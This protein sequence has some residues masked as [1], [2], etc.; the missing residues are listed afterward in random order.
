MKH[1]HSLLILFTL[2]AL[3][4]NA[5]TV[6]GINYEATGA[7]TA[8]VVAKWP[9]Y[10]GTVT[11]PRTVTYS[12]VSYTVNEIDNQCFLN[13]EFLESVSLPATL[14]TIGTNAF[15][16]CVLLNT[17]T[18]PNSVNYIG[19]RAFANCSKLSKITLGNNLASIE[20]GVFFHCAN[21]KDITLPNSV[22]A[23]R[24]L[25]FAH[26]GIEQ[27]N[28][29]KNVKTI[30]DFAFDDCASLK[31]IFIDD[32]AS[33]CMRDF[34]YFNMNPLSQARNL[35]LNDK[36]LTTIDI[37][38]GITTIKPFAFA[39]C[40]ASEVIIP[41]SVKTIDLSAFRGCSRIKTV[42]IPN[43]VS[44]LIS[45]NLGGYP[46]FP[47]LTK[48]TIG[49][50]IKTLPKHA[51]D[52]CYRL[53]SIIIYE[54]V[55]S[56]DYNA[57]CYCGFTYI[58]LPKTMRTLNAA[59]LS[60]NK[61]E[62]IVLNPELKRMEGAVFN[63]CV[64]LS[65]IHSRVK[66]PNQMEFVGTSHFNN[67]KTNTCILYVPKGCVQAYRKHPNWSVFSNIQEDVMNTDI[68][69][70]GKTDVEDLNILIN[71]IL[72]LDYAGANA[73]ACDVDFNGKVDVEDVN[74]V[75]NAILLNS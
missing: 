38:E 21:L 66:D 74:V 11:I 54:G 60:C 17:V 29:F 39:S 56:L 52:F 30:E 46:P 64:S 49:S 15:E 32:L 1:F 53:N 48:L 13:A 58:V 35:Y 40:S 3:H 75:I 41:A 70:D 72:D 14:L 22:T 63:G 73:T 4:A 20:S 18:I 57:F 71:Q 36:L 47:E 50:G 68:N 67:V 42:F 10:S 12:G 2:F 7:K 34:D 19:A 28:I 23:I 45:D 16:G 65:A 61:L 8:K 31:R 62:E 9:N 6:N 5:F 51:F 37:P 25:A 27:I 69:H 59:F 26:S 33:W 44:E 55:E 43:T 24:S